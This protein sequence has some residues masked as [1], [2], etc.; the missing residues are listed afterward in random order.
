MAARL[1]SQQKPLE[2]QAHQALLQGLRHR[3]QLA[4]WGP[5]GPLWL[6]GPPAEPAQAQRAGDPASWQ[7]RDPGPGPEISTHTPAI[8]A[9]GAD[10]APAPSAAFTVLEHSSQPSRW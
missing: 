8:L 4:L 1:G 7:H 9:W 5:P 3:E 2:L 10:G 6:P